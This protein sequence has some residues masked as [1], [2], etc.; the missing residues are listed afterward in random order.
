MYCKEKEHSK[1]CIFF[2]HKDMIHLVKEVSRGDEG[3]DGG[4][5]KETRAGEKMAK[6]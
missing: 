3:D 1:N 4:A 5:L 2:L 6:K